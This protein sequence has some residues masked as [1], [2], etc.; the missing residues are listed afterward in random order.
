MIW[1]PWH[2]LDGD[3]YL[4]G[5]LAKRAVRCAGQTSARHVVAR[6]EP[7]TQVHASASTVVTHESPVDFHLLPSSKFARRSGRCGTHS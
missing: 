6:I 2:M 1:S 3:I 7:R 5:L 4:L